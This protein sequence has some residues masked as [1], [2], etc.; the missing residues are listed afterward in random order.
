MIGARAPAELFWQDGFCNC[1]VIRAWRNICSTR[2]G[3]PQLFK[4]S[5]VSPVCFERID[6][7]STSRRVDTLLTKTALSLAISPALRNATLEGNRLHCD[8]TR[9]V[10]TSYL[11]VVPIG[12]VLVP[13]WTGTEVLWLATS[14]IQGDVSLHL[15]C[16]PHT[17]LFFLPVFSTRTREQPVDTCDNGRLSDKMARFQTITPPG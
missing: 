14:A 4:S 11:P 9:A 10:E 2:T 12:V 16:S 15:G 6:L 7:G 17:S 1:N 8:P 3:S 13:S 5:L